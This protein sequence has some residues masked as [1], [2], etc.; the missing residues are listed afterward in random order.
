MNILYVGTLPPHPGGTAI[1]G[2]QLLEG[3]ARR[4][5]QI[6]AIAPATP[7]AIAGGDR[8]AAA[9]PE[10][11]V[12]RFPIPYFETS[13]DLPAAVQYRSVEGNGISAAWRHALSATR[14]DV[15]IIGRET[16]A[17]HVPDLARAAGLP[18]LL[19]VHGGTFFG[20]VNNFSADDRERLLEQFRKTDRIVAVA[21]HLAQ[22]LRVLGF[23]DVKTIPNAVDPA[24]FFPRA[25]DPALLRRLGIASGSPIVA[26]VSN[27][28]SIKR[29]LDIVDAAREVLRWRP[30]TVFLIVG[31]GPCREPM[32]RACAKASLSGH[33]R[34]VGWVDHDRVPDYINLAD[35]VVMPSESEAFALIYLETQA[36]ERVL[37]A[38]DI[39]AARRVID[40]RKSGLLFRKGDLADLTAKILAVAGQ[41]ALR[42][43]IGKAARQ[44]ALN[45]SVERLVTSYEALIR[46]LADRSAVDLTERSSK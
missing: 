24:R 14:P 22:H 8:F 5:H 33:F 15:V 20:M 41:P 11:H 27:L 36:C 19:I 25:K 35:M 37:I 42:A 9:H 46:E 10:I 32:E 13:P 44:S 30:A 18:A 39:E 45:Y 16:F 7:A 26:H 3:L 6:E 40:D 1:V 29:P 12:T 34:F 31:D 23:D 2:Y 28:K 4:G 21:E 43:A 17:W 38:S